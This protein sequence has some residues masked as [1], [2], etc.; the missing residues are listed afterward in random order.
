MVRLNTPFESDVVPCVVPFKKILA[1]GIG[2]P[3]SS[4]IVPV[5]V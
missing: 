3:L 1:D 4:V 5:I 2:L